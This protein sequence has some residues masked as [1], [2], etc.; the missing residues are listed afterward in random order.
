MPAARASCRC[1]GEQ[2]PVTRGVLSDVGRRVLLLAVGGLLMVGAS[3]CASTG[4]PAT[5]GTPLAPDSP[6]ATASAASS[7]SSAEATASSVASVVDLLPAELDGTE[8]HTFAVGQEMTDRLVATLGADP[9]D[10]HERQ[11]LDQPGVVPID[12][13]RKVG[14]VHPLGSLRSG[15]LI[16]YNSR[17][18][19][20]LGSF[21]CQCQPR[22]FR[23]GGRV[24][25]LG[26]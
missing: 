21:A 16:Q 12:G 4:E 22:T 9:A 17:R 23:T 19:R 18:T 15:P 5:S 25:L 3:A 20:I 24:D 7:V 1:Q 11:S 2:E 14:I 26:G 13:G 8:L 10:Q 6:E